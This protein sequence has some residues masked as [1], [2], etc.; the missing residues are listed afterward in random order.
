MAHIEMKHGHRRR[1]YIARM[2]L[3]DRR[4][5]ISPTRAAKT[6]T[7]EAR[8]IKTS[9]SLSETYITFALCQTG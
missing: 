6:R 3:E 9:T 7:E 5:P 8:V 2:G 1:A 4:V